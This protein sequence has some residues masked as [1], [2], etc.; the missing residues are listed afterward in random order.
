MPAYLTDYFKK[1]HKQ[2]MLSKEHLI[3]ELKEKNFD[4]EYQIGTLKEKVEQQENSFIASEK[5]KRN[6]QVEMD[7][8]TF[9]ITKMENK[10]SLE[11]KLAESKIS[12]L[13]AQLSSKDEVISFLKRELEKFK[14]DFRRVQTELN[15]KQR[16]SISLSRQLQSM[17]S[18]KNVLSKIRTVENLNEESD[19]SEVWET[20][21]NVKKDVD[22]F[23]KELEKSILQKEYKLSAII[24]E[25]D[26]QILEI[27][28][29]NMKRINSIKNEHKTSTKT[30][31]AQFELEID[32]LKQTI[33]KLEEA[34][35]QLNQK[36][37]EFDTTQS[38][39]KQYLLQIEELQKLVLILTK[40]KDAK[41][42]LIRLER[43]VIKTFVVQVE[44][45][46]RAR[47]ELQQDMVRLKEFK[48]QHREDKFKIL[49]VC[50]QLLL[51]YVK[52]KKDSLPEAYQDLSEEDKDHLTRM[53]NNINISIAKYI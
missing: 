42:E 49:N 3:S 37:V 26:K 31:V 11:R 13:E 16:E 29:E 41:E 20:M 28:S 9:D 1:L 50:E 23:S 47:V 40:D 2:I 52:K 43:E 38:I 15:D 48:K 35:F 32:N 44:Y 33:A 12:S 45:K 51:K 27:T 19:L 14:H 8:L 34:Q 39:N 25:K 7:K 21:R 53:L 46:E 30:L 4:Y 6:H 18:S 36:L 22:S 17:Q 24:N 10:I 5:I